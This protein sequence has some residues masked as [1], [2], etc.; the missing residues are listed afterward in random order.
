MHK[1][2]LLLDNY[3]SFTYNLYHYVTA[4]AGVEVTVRR[5]DEITL[6]EAGEFDRMILSPGPGLP[7]EA[8]ILLPL[9]K[10]YAR[11]KSMLGVCLGLQA[12]SEAFGGTLKQLEKVSHGV[13]REVIV[14]D[15]DDVL[16][17]DIPATFMAGRYHS[18]VANRNTLPSCFR[19]TAEDSNGN[20]MAIRHREHDICAVQFHP[21]SILTPHGRQM[22]R[23]WIENKPVDISV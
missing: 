14:N 18:W 9:V 2:I 8:G 5:N 11:F 10:K 21:E 3:D 17:K 20:I 6:E 22:M 23:N 12:M 13:S 15:S 7:S 1:K 19:I 16:F 4:E